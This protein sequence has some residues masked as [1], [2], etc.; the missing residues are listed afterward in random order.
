MNPG[1]AILFLGV[2]GAWLIW[3]MLREPEPQRLYQRNPNTGELVIF[4]TTPCMSCGADRVATPER[5]AEGLVPYD[6]IE[7]YCPCCGFNVDPIEN[8]TGLV[9]QGGTKWSKTGHS[10]YPEYAIYRREDLNGK[11][12]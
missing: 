6:R 5:T 10:L 12:S 11:K 9:W 2:V 1:V 7:A 4:Q 3:R 8:R